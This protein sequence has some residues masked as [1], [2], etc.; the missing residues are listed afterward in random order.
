MYLGHFPNFLEEIGTSPITPRSWVHVTSYENL[1]QG[2]DVE[3]VQVTA[4]YTC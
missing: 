4:T 1:I 2:S 3:R